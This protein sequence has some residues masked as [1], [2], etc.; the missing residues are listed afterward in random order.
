MS[1]LFK[2]LEDKLVI[3]IPIELLVIAAE[4][5]S[6]NPLIVNDK[7]DFAEKVLF[8]LEHNLGSAETGLSGFQQLLDEAFYEVCIGGNDCVELKE[9]QFR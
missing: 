2:K 1:I 4:N 9:D 7:H 5:N 6:E 8:E 3:E